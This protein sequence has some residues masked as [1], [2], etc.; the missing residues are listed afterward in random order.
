MPSLHEHLWGELQKTASL[1]DVYS[2]IE[3]PLVPVLLSMEEAGVLV[4][5][6]RIKIINALVDGLPESVA[7]FTPT[8]GG[9][10][11]L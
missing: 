10:S 11:P 3:Q 1:R 9:R 8:V 5:G 4:A 7:D 2:N 6:H